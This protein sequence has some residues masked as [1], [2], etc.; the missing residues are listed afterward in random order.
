MYITCWRECLQLVT[1]KQAYRSSATGAVGVCRQLIQ[2]QLPQRKAQLY[3][4][5]GPGG[6][7]PLISAAQAGSPPL[8]IAAVDSANQ[9]V[10]ILN[11]N[12]DAVDVS[13][14]KLTG[15]T[16]ITLRAG[17]FASCSQTQ[18]LF[19]WQRLLLICHEFCGTHRPVLLRD[20]TYISAVGDADMTFIDNVQ[21]GRFRLCP[22]SDW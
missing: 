20:C 21:S 12:P 3:N 16:S 17:T 4:T 10:Q 18:A 22:M 11:N 19:R 2:D 7:Q 6:S 13:D 15:S 5:Y 9:F 14:Y 8:S 1:C